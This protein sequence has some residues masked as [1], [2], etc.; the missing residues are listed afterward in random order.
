MPG[1]P[2]PEVDEQLGPLQQEVRSPSEQTP[3]QCSTL[4]AQPTMHRSSEACVRC[5]ILRRQKHMQRL[6]PCASGFTSEL[7]VLSAGNLLRT[8]AVS[9]LNMLWKLTSFCHGLFLLMLL[10]CQVEAVLQR[11]SSY[12]K[13]VPAVMASALEQQLKELRPK[14]TVH[15]TATGQ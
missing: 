9:V 5:Y 7:Q 8:C 1:I 12:R 4:Y 3:Q 14:D 13:E 11:L 15:R 10:P 6:N 2:L